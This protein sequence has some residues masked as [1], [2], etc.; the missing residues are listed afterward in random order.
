MKFVPRTPREGV[1]VSKT[2]PLVE[3]AILVAGIGGV[4]LLV[5][6]LLA[7]AVYLAVSFL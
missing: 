3:A 7:L 5:L 4:L 1:N 6:A 2:H